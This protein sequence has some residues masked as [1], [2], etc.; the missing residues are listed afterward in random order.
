MAHVGGPSRP[1]RTIQEAKRAL[2]RQLL[3]HPGVSGV[4]IETAE[5]GG[6]RIKVYLAEDDPALRSSVPAT[7]D[8]Y[9]VAVE[10][11]GRIVPRAGLRDDDRGALA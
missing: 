2:S 1:G 6:E 9:P 3:Q 5:G 4:G 7:V 10:V 11:I 8:G